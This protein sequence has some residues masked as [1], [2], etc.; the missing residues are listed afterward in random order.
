MQL[1]CM[2]VR[3]YYIWMLYTFQLFKWST[4]EKM[5]SGNVF[6]EPSITLQ[7]LKKKKSPK[8]PLGALKIG[9]KRQ[10]V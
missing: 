3:V 1:D 10:K 9:A 5:Q 6:A 7:C 8:Y 4:E 2:I